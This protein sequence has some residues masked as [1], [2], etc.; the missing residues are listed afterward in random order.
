MTA[1]AS[2]IATGAAPAALV[3]PLSA[4]HLGIPVPAPPPPSVGGRQ[5]D[6]VNRVWERC[7]R[8]RN[9]V[10]ADAPSHGWRLDDS[11]DT[12]LDSVGGADGRYARSGHGSAAGALAGEQH[13]AAAFDGVHDAI[14]VARAPDIS[15][16]RAYT[17][18]LWVRP[19]AIDDR[20][21][22]LVGREATLAAG[23]QGSGLWLS[24]AGLGFERWVGGVKAG[25][26][27]SAGLTPGAWSAVTA[28]YDGAMM[29]LYVNG[30]QVGS[31]ATTAPLVAIPSPLEIGATDGGRSGFF[32]GAL[33]EVALYE[34]ALPRSH[35]AAHVRAG[36]APPCSTI[37]GETGLTYTPS[38]ED[39]GDTLR[40]VTTASATGIPAS[41]AEV[42]ESATPVDDNG[43]LVRP[44]IT[45]LTP[46][47]TVTGTVQVIATVAGL[48][49]DRI[50]FVVDG[51]VRYAKDEAPY[52]YTW[53]TAAEPNGGH[54]VAVRVLGP[55]SETPAVT[56]IAVRVSNPTV[57]PTPLPFGK[58]SMYAEFNEG[59]VSTADNLLDNV[60]PSRGFPLA[61]LGWPLTWR[62]DPYN[63]AFWRFF[64][65]G[66]RPEASLLYQCQSTGAARYCDRLVA[67][68]RSYVTYDATRPSEPLTFDNNHAAAYR[69][70]TLINYMFKLKRLGLLP[71]D[72]E[73]GLRGSL[74][75]LG[76]FLANPAH[77]EGGFNHGF[78]EGA[79]LLL[80]AAN[81]PDLPGAAAWRV[82]A[83]N[84]LQTMLDTNLDGDGVEI[85]NSPFY[86][87][88][89]L[90]IVYQIARWAALYE[91]ALAQPYAE[92]AQ[93]ML[94]HAAYVTQPNGY[95]PML[96]A[97]ATTFMP[98]QDPT[99][100]GPM[101]DADPEFAFAFTRG[102]RGAHPPDG[103]YLFP[104]S[105]L[106]LMRSPFA[107]ASSPTQQTFV[108]FDAG[109]Y[110][111]EHSDLDALGITMTTHGSTVLP[112]SGLFTYTSQP[113]RSYFHGTRAHNTVVVDGRD[114]A[115]GS[116]TAGTH[117]QSGG[118]TWAAGTST[119]YAGVTHRRSVVVLRQG[120]S[121]VVDRL[122]SGA[123]HSYTQTWHLAP[124]AVID[125][126]GLDVA[127]S[128]GSGKRVLTIRQA[129]PAGTTLAAV[130]GQTAPMQG[131]YSASYGS[132]I[133]AYAL[134]YG[135][136][137]ASTTFATLLAAGPYAPQTSTVVRTPVSGGD[138]VDV[139]VGGSVGYTVTIAA[140]G[141]TISVG[142]GA[143]PTAPTPS[144]AV[145]PARAPLPVPPLVLSGVDQQA[146]QPLPARPG[147]IPVVMFHS[148]CAVAGCTAYNTTPTELVRELL[149]L[150]RAGYTTISIDQYAK[151][152]R[153]QPV[154]LPAR[155]ILLTFDDA[156]LDTFRGA[157]AIL[158]ALGQ[159]A[160]IFAVTQW[161]ELRD[162]RVLR[163]DELARMQASGRWDVQLHAG[164]GHNLIQV[165]VTTDGAPVQKP[166]YAWRRYD[167]TRYPADDHLESFDGWKARAEEDIA[168]GEALLKTHVP[169]HQRLA[170]ALPYGDY[171]QIKTND[172]RIPSELRSYLEG[173]FAA[174][175]VQPSPDPPFSARGKEAWR[176]TVRST[177][178][179]SDLYAWL[180]RHASG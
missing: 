20:Y 31:R 140:D 169:G 156:R 178:T 168:Q 173:Q 163:W 17:F 134:E 174:Y 105:G 26:T 71:A 120:L 171:G 2:V 104:S 42:D 125:V 40:V 23:R 144:I 101:A 161:V 142:G 165:G 70:M 124:D 91:P 108:T 72:L 180:S 6:T 157:D 117:G 33:D 114:Q 162:S 75:R 97:T 107:S 21:R 58:E 143:C 29:R 24:A 52:Q 150:E 159:R 126:R 148:V 176:Y 137:T 12:A 133:P 3:S 36:S 47:A 82:T 113:D 152:M 63:D 81:L 77:F 118:S 5:P 122:A 18:E 62:E 160:T 10:G 167:A 16:T 112:E 14:A 121:L 149:M 83:V 4:P 22:Y 34:R 74:E 41:V 158:A 67:I 15:G 79:A 106:F 30:R 166:F 135:R 179:A 60:W 1:I 170:F 130:K 68:L 38:I 90:G 155:P 45:T 146:F 164:Q 39:L 8:F 9:V 153:S 111:T 139:C 64:Y 44:T 131:W 129:D 96:G 141:T 35:V 86:H 57:Y 53:Y 69:A 147:Q 119:L 51:V 93:R 76:V 87:V 88:Y 102:A 28:T 25:I 7:R 100:Y 13:P 49:L 54:T 128:N 110:R 132:K 95:L 37:T 127:V 84:R 73:Q 65:Y 177:T 138:R 116:A 50:E 80:L 89:V 32:S 94:R 109:P 78:N 48:P 85:E 61:H 66:L 145:D 154:T 103:T 175:F 55:R 92:A 27:Y 56:T 115:A 136:K 43:Q 99:V 46:G 11:G 19:S 151:F 172:S 123:S 98:S 59:D